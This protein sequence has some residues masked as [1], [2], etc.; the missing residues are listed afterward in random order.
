MD[1]NLIAVKKLRLSEVRNP[2]RLQL[3]LHLATISSNEAV[4]L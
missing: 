2:N 1:L 4:T 3:K